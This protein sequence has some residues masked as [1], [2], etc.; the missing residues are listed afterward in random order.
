MNFWET[1][2]NE[3][4]EAK[5]DFD[6]SNNFEV[7]PNNTDL[8]AVIDKAS[9]ARNEFNGDFISIEWLV[10]APALYAKRKVFQ[11]IKVMDEKD[12]TADK[13]K[14]M[15]AAIDANAGGK[16][17]AAGEQPDDSMLMKALAGKQMVIKVQ[18][19]E[20]EGSDGQPRT[21]NWVCAVS[22]KKKVAAKPAAVEIEIEDDG[23][24]F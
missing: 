8:L 3:T 5:T 18:V 9:W 20:M 16:L 11:N 10:L 21:G 13:A 14:R 17:R 1:S 12:K 6:A 22:P 23:L 4:I 15:L 19:W 7:I 24:S 2:D